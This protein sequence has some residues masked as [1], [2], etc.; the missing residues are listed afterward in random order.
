[1]SLEIDVIEKLIATQS[2]A[3]LV[4]GLFCFSLIKDRNQERGERR[5][6]YKDVSNITSKYNE[7][8]LKIQE[9]IM[10]LKDAIQKKSQD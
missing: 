1:M 3:F 4:M 10:E 2:A 5:S 8:M 9:A 7:A 6:A